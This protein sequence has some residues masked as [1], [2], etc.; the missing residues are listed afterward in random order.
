MAQAQ[1]AA[2]TLRALYY[3]MPFRVADVGHLPQSFPS[4]ISP[5]PL[6]KRKLISLTTDLYI[7]ILDAVRHVHV[8]SN[9]VAGDKLTTKNGGMFTN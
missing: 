1:A 9:H 2:G 5:L 4:A 3:T 6:L 8:V 7:C